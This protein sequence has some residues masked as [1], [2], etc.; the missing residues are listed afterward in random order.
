MDPCSVLTAHIQN[1]DEK[2]VSQSQL[3]PLPNAQKLDNSY[4]TTYAHKQRSQMANWLCRWL[5]GVRT[6]TRKSRMPQHTKKK[7]QAA[8]PHHWADTWKR[9][10]GYACLNDSQM[11]ERWS[12][13]RSGNGCPSTTLINVRRKHRN[14]YSISSQAVKES[15]PQLEGSSFMFLLKV[16][17][18]SGL[19]VQAQLISNDTAVRER[20]LLQSLRMP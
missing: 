20:R 11:F 4:E 10:H 15:S 5:G 2:V 18:A 7:K 19:H 1:L 13:E 8:L 6:L 17:G 14:V 3:W 12:Q 9:Y 16:A